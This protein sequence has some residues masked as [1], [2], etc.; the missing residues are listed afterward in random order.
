MTFKTV[1]P[2]AGQIWRY[3]DKHYMLLRLA[4]TGYGYVSDFAW[5]ALEING[6]GRMYPIF[7]KYLKYKF[8]Q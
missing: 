2:Q 3:H 1:K 4:D 5:V 7:L 8:V 6:S